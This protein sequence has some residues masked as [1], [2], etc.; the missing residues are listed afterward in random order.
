MV[1]GR[2]IDEAPIN[3]MTWRQIVAFTGRPIL[4]ITITLVKIV[5]TSKLN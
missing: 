3:I 4:K 5:T 2:A 1:Y